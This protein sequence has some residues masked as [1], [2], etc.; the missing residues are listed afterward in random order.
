YDE[1]VKLAI[2]HEVDI[3]SV[4]QRRR[5]N[6]KKI[7]IIRAS[8]E[9]LGVI[10]SQLRKRNFSRNRNSQS[11]I[12]QL[13]QIKDQLE[14]HKEIFHSPANRVIILKTIVSIL[15]QKSAY[16]ELEDYVRNTFEEFEANSWFSKDNHPLRLLMRV[17]CIN[18]LQKLL[19]LEEAQEVISKLHAEIKQF[20]R[21]N[22]HEFAFHYFSNQINNHKLSGKLDQSAEVL[23][24]ALR[25]REL[26][27]VDSHI[28][29][30]LISRADQYFKEG[31]YTQA[32]A[33]IK[34]ITTQKV[35]QEVDIELRFY[36]RVFELINLHES[37]QYK[38]CMAAYKSLR[39]KYKSIL[40]DDFYAKA[41]RF[42]DILMRMARAKV[43]GK[44][45]FLKSAY[46][47]FVDEY[48]ASE[49]GDNQ[50]MPYEVYLRAKLEEKSY[51]QLFLEWVQHKKR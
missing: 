26:I 34:E 19:R 9:V 29:Y 28:L 15:I 13:E 50:I 38:Q 30:L 17:W 1:M 6:L 36:V 43:E 39:K 3:E 46:R 22:Y 31:D 40:K 47:N 35:F 21:Q 42:L 44:R 49:V 24:Q 5:E 33:Q 8:S 41:D 7:E 45:V 4:I 48:P 16:A 18:S 51:Y 12:D 37:G 10:T 14:E 27:A 25:Q 2:N 23:N 20:K 32:L 11:V